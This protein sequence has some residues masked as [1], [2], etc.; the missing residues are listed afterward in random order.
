MRWGQAAKARAAQR[1]VGAAHIVVVAAAAQPQHQVERGLLLDVVVRQR[2][3][4]LEL[5]ARKDQALLVRRNSLLVLRTRALIVSAAPTKCGGEKD[6]VLSR[7][8]GMEDRGGEREREA[9]GSSP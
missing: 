2:A 8:R 4:I 3:A 9:P 1:G 6:G 7:G 5:L